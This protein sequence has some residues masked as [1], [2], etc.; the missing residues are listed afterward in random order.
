MQVAQMIKAF[1]PLQAC[2]EGYWIGKPDPPPLS[3][4]EATIQFMRAAR[5]LLYP[6]AISNP[7]PVP[8]TQ[9]FLEQPW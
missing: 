1:A 2:V 6:Q 9:S 4:E 8:N 3:E 7:S 5:A